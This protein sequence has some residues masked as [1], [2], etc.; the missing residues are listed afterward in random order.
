M[1]S[2]LAT[3]VGQKGKGMDRPVRVGL[4]GPI[5]IVDT[6]GRSPVVGSKL[7]LLL[8]MLGLAS[9]HAVSDDCLFEALWRDEQ[10][11]NPA[12]ALQALVSHLRRLLGRD[13]VERRGSGYVLALDADSVDAVRF[14]RLVR[15]GRAAAADGDQ[16]AAVHRFRDGVALCRGAPLVQLVDSAFAQEAGTRLNEL[17]LAA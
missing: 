13:A 3:P 14:E 9:P 10:P 4:L 1:L 16:N 8:A 17:L 12:N 5:E 11:A 15:E 6:T 7:Q 2:P